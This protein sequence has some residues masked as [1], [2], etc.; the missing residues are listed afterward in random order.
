MNRILINLVLIIGLFSTQVIYAA[1]DYSRGKEKSQTCSACH[2][3]DGNSDNKM[4]PKLAGQY[5]NYLINSLNSYKNGNRNNAI[6]TSFAT[7][8]SNED[9]EDL[10]T[11]FS[12]QN[13]LKVL[14]IK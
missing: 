4:Y 1:G 11:Y 7:G 13:G 8:L 14:P 6:M 5:K 9:I 2:G 10:A 12:E 3:V